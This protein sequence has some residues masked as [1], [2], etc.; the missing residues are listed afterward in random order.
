M[1]FFSFLLIFHSFNIELKYSTFIVYIYICIYI[2][3]YT[4][5]SLEDETRNARRNAN[6]NPEWWGDFSQLQIQIKSKFGFELVPRDTEEFKFDKNL[7]SNLFPDTNQNTRFVRDICTNQT[8]EGYRGLVRGRWDWNACCNANQNPEWWEEFSQ[9]VKIMKLKF[10]GISQHA[11]GPGSQVLPGCRVRPPCYSKKLFVR[12]ERAVSN[13]SSEY[14]TKFS[15]VKVEV[16]FRISCM[17]R[18]LWWPSTRGISFCIP[19]TISS[20]IFGNGL[21]WVPQ[22]SF[23]F[24]RFGSSCLMLLLLL[25][26]K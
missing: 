24:F 6:Q 12:M 9:L 26:K 13:C 4:A 15:I 16:Y 25:H 14:K 18:N 8:K 23:G 22:N 2:C 21:G 17:K 5:C 20:L 10:R 7:K 19:L 11:P 1:L 3:I